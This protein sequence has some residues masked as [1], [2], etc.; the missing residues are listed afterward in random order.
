MR[1]NK[2]FQHLIGKMFG[3]L[4]KCGSNTTFSNHKLS[5]KTIKKSEIKSLKDFIS[6][7]IYHPVE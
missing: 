7:S 2:I 3:A 6:H 1:Y 4:L 5:F